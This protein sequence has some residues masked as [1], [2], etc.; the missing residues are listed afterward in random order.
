MLTDNRAAQSALHPTLFVQGNYFPMR[1]REDGQP[2]FV[3]EFPLK[4]DAVTAR[5]LPVAIE[6]HPTRPLE[7]HAGRLESVRLVPAP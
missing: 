5:A 6:I 1:S 7:M 2:G 3:C 4:V